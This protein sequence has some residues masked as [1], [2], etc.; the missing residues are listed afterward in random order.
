MFELVALLDFASNDKFRVEPAPSQLEFR[1][2]VP[3]AILQQLTVLPHEDEVSLS[4]ATVTPS[5]RQRGDIV[6]HETKAAHKGDNLGGPLGYETAR[7]TT[8]P[9]AHFD[10]SQQL[11]ATLQ[12]IEFV[13]LQVEFQ[14]RAV[15]T[16][17]FRCEHRVEGYAR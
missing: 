13:P 14:E 12:G 1:V 11:R 4:Q 2:S 10:R 17:E 6:Q 5:T 3:T 8:L 16:I 9:S 7:E 15:I